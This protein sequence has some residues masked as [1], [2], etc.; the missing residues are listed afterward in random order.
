MAYVV[1]LIVAALLLCAGQA[2]ALIPSSS[3]K[4]YMTTWIQ[5]NGNPKVWYYTREEA[6][7][8]MSGQYSTYV[9]ASRPYDHVDS[10][11]CYLRNASGVA[12]GATT[13]VE[14]TVSCPANSSSVSGGCQCNSGYHEAGGAC[15]ADPNECEAL[16]GQSAGPKNY[17]G[18]G[19]TFFFCDSWNT[20]GGG[21]CVAKVERQFTWESPAGSGHFFSSG[22]G[23]YTGS[24]GTTCDGGG[25]TDEGPAPSTPKPGDGKE[26]DTP[27]PGTAAPSPCPAGQAP[28]EVNGTTSCYPRGT[29]GNVEETHK[30]SSTDKD[31]N[32]TDTERTT[33]CTAGTCTTTTTECKTPAG[34]STA[35]CTSSSTSGSASGTCKPGNGLAMCGEGTSE[36]SF[37]GSCSQGFVA[38][39][40]DAVLNA[41]AMEQHKRNCE[42][43]STEGAAQTEVTT[44][45]AK[46]GDRTGD[47][48]NNG[49]VD[50]SSRID[51]SDALG[52]GGCSLNKTLTVRGYTFTLPFN[53]LCD[54]LAAFGWLLVSV[55]MLL[56]G[57][58]VMRG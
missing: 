27:D 44:E 43:L 15:V 38:K 9:G 25:G 14:R 17:E 53:N 10:S 54:S 2:H 29:D 7:Q 12:F 1:R 37:T 26:P 50:M 56:A 31:G 33:K 42:V 35:T 22:E 13:W 40:D 23:F 36:S 58:I 47:N 32:K 55:A 24:T 11:Y 20:A 41:M 5:G 16:A 57:R 6:C 48:P 21:K 34:G 3:V 18:R 46:T 8:D 19:D 4:Q 49:S 51:T 28:G 52:G 39:S 30:D 45:M